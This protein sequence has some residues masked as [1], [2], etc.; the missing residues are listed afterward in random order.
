MGKF[1]FTFSRS[2]QQTRIVKTFCSFFYIEFVFF[3]LHL[4]F[5][6]TYCFICKVTNFSMSKPRSQFAKINLIKGGKC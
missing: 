1:R 5:D 4:L 6:G 2:K 3:N